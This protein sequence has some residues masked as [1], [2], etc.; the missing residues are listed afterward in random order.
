MKQARH[1][2]KRQPWRE[3]HFQ[4][5]WPEDLTDAFVPLSQHNLLHKRDKDDLN[6]ACSFIGTGNE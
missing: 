1:C 4:G 6:R 2:V 3:V 5:N